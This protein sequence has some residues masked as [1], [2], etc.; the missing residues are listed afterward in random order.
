ILV[1]KSTNHFHQSFARISPLILYCAAGRPYPNDP[2]VTPYKKAPR[3]IWPINEAVNASGHETDT[4]AGTAG[5]KG[6]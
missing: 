5:R 4:S 6:G 3:D 2:R 1:V